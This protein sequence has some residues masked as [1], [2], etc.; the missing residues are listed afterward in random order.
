MKK[1]LLLFFV[2][3]FF[4]PALNAQTDITAVTLATYNAYSGEAPEPTVPYYNGLGVRRVI[5]ADADGDG[6]QEIIATD[7]S[8]GG[9]VHV[10]KYDEGVLEIIWSSPV[11]PTSVVPLQDFLESVIV[12]EME[13]LKLFLNKV[14]KPE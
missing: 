1:I 12:M 8:N 2:T 14:V 5:V 11:S 13:I 9:R 6:T 10:M 7:Y 3:L 4:L